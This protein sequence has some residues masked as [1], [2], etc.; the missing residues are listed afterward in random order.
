[1]LLRSRRSQDP[2]GRQLR[3]A[4]LACREH[5]NKRVKERDLTLILDMDPQA[6]L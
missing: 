1:L 4:A 3:Q 5:F 6:V 2:A